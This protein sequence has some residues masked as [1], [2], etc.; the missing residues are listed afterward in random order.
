MTTYDFICALR[1][2]K[3]EA[4]SSGVNRLPSLS[5]LEQAVGSLEM[6]DEEAVN[7]QSRSQ[8]LEWSEPED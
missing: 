8:D 4:V 5:R 3:V 6:Q 1:K 7:E 2:A